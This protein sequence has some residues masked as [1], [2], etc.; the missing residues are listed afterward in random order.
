LKCELFL[1]YLIQEFSHFI[2]K[3]IKYQTI[4]STTLRG[5]KE[6]TLMLFQGFP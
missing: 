2:D 6:A 4:H 1:V 5:F 3:S